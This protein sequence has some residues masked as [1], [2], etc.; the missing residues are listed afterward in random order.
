MEIN[1]IDS[2]ISRQ[3]AAFS[4]MACQIEIATDYY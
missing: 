1:K 3:L 4:V 2:L